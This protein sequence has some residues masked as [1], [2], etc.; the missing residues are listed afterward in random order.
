MPAYESGTDE[1]GFAIFAMV[2]L[3]IGF[4]TLAFSVL[5]YILQSLGMYTIAKRRGIHHPWLAW[6]PVG[7]GWMLGSISDQYQYVA[8]GR[9]K[10]KRKALLILEILT[11]VLSGAYC[12]SLFAMFARIVVESGTAVSEEQIAAQLLGMVGSIGLMALLML[13][14]AISMAVVRYFALYD[15]YNSCNPSNSVM[16]L[17]LSIFINVTLPFLVFSCR[18]MDKGMPPRQSPADPPTQPPKEPWV[19]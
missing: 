6:I 17:V 2:Y 10:N 8:K 16:Y 15:L 19:Q 4:F 3:V 11:L 12:G 5:S 18:K 9:V 14:L 13:A 1:M 7:S